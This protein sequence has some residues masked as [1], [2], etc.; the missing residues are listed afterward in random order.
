MPNK[1][2]LF[3]SLFSVSLILALI[4]FTAVPDTYGS[5]VDGTGPAGPQRTYDKGSVSMYYEYDQPAVLARQDQRII[6]RV[7][8]RALR[9][10]KDDERLPLNVAIVLDKSGSMRSQNKIEHAKQ[11]AIDMLSYLDEDDIVSVVIFA[12]YAQIVVQ[13]GP[14]TDK[15]GVVRTI[16]SIRADG[17]TALY[18]GISL[19]AREV[20]RHASSDYLNRIVLLSDGLANVGPQSNAEIFRLAENF[21]GDGVHC[22]AIGVGLD[23]NEQLL[24]GLAE[25]SGGN[26]YYARNGD[27]LPG[28]FEREV[29]RSTTVIAKDIRIKVY[30]ANGSRLAGVIGPATEQSPRV[31]ETWIPFL[32][33]GD[34]KYRLIEL[35]LPRLAP[36]DGRQ[37]AQLTIE[38]FDPVHHITQSVDVPLRLDVTTDERLVSRRQ[39]TGVI[40]DAYLRR[41]AERKQEAV[42]YARRGDYRGASRI[43]VQTSV[44]LESAAEKY[45]DDDLYRASRQNRWQSQ[46]VLQDQEYDRELMNSEIMNINQEFWG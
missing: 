2:V 30:A 28:I 17:S 33:G 14:L 3:V 25:N 40:K 27:D 36:G 43:L 5:R 1:S 21:M 8:A 12:D 15:A 31:A 37:V 39:N 38:Y 26:Y 20:A 35:D 23:F 13:A 6:L 19:G 22:S 41:M 4:G 44:E 45:K 10:A 18:S 24:S 32:Y 34:D 46:K 29:S 7:V 42:A 11:G 9:R 16:Q